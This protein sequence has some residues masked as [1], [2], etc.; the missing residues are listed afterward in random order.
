MS[1]TVQLFEEAKYIGHTAC[2]LQSATSSR[3]FAAQ[4]VGFRLTLH[5]NYV[6]DF[7]HTWTNVATSEISGEGY[8]P[9]GET[10]DTA[11]DNSTSMPKQGDRY[12]HYLQNNGEDVIWMY[13]AADFTFT[14][15]VVRFTSTT[16]EDV[17]GKLF[18]VF[19]RDEALTT[20]GNNLGIAGTLAGI[21]AFLVSTIV[22]DVAGYTLPDKARV[23]GGQPDGGTAAMRWV[24]GTCPGSWNPGAYQ[25]RIFATGGVLIATVAASNSRMVCTEEYIGVLCD[26]AVFPAVTQDVVS[27]QFQSSNSNGGYLIARTFDTPLEP[28]GKAVRITFPDGYVFKFNFEPVEA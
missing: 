21:Y 12:P 23:A 8:T 17:D 11:V 15:V 14:H 26:E 18:C 9:G 16:S 6:Y 4:N 3:V 20:E 1:Y 2:H 24:D 28:D 19:E 13:P 22:T 27:Y 7:N 5:N 10:F 25:H